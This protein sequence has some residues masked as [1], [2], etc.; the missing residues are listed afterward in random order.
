MRDIERESEGEAGSL[1]EPDAGL[2]PGAPGSHPE[3]KTDALLLSHPG[4]PLNFFFP[5]FYVN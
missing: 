1:Q 3:P 2:D 5:N 4:V